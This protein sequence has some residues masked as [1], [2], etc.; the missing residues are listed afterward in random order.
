MIRL[1]L[2]EAPAPLDPT[3]SPRQWLPE[4]RALVDALSATIADGEPEGLRALGQVMGAPELDLVVTPLTAR[5]AVLGAQNGRAFYHHELRLRQPMPE[6]LEPE[7]AVWQAGTTPQWSDGVLAE[8]KYFS[9][10]QDAPFPAYNPNHRRKW[11][12][13]E[14]L[15][16]ASRFFWHPQMTRFELYVSARLNELL[17]IIHWYG[18]DEIF[19]PRCPEHQG[20]LLY[21]ELCPRC[22]ALATPYW[23]LDPASPGQHALGMG[24]AHNALEHLES[25]WTA[26]TQEINT[27]RLHAT[28]RGRLDASSDAVGYMRAHWNRVTAWSTGSWVERFLI[29]GVDYFSSLEALLLNVGQATQHLVCGTLELDPQHY[30]AGRTRR[31]LQDIAARVLLALEW[32]DPESSQGQEAEAALEPHLEALGELSAAL[33]ES[34]ERMGEAL[35]GFAECARTFSEVAELFPEP[36]AESFLGFGYRFVDADVFAQAGAMQLAQ[37]IED[38]APQTFAMLTDPLDSAL[39]LTQW[40]GFEAPGRLSG[41]LHGWLV[42]QLGPEHPLSEQARFEAFANEEPRHDEEATLFAALPEHPEALLTQEGRLRP[43]ATLRRAAFDASL[44]TRT[45][46]QALPEGHDDTRLDVAAA[47]VDGQLRLVVE[48]PEFGSILDHLQAGDA[49]ESWLTPELCEP[50]YELLENSLVCWLPAPRRGD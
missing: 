43:N 39:A 19:R 38:A 44:I 48:S 10:F 23:E 14:L 26:I 5:A 9:F 13:H 29:D 28:P 36:I 33:L 32:L 35:D 20:R 34:P 3:A 37:G 7:L 18:F 49:P 22:E 21:R 46:G 24:A 25:E 30:L 1:T 50:L 11:R 17:P 31:Q 16:G 8:P 4:P 42:A 41:R 27:G 45:I 40:E 15:H 2:P 12:A 6:H 47:L